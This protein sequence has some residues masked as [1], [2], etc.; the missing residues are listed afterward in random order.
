MKISLSADVGEGFGP[1]RLGNDDA[2]MPYISSANIACGMHAGDPT[3]MARTIALAKQHGVSIGAHPGFRDIQG[4]GRRHIAMPPQE[5][6]W[7]VTY[8]IGALQSLAAGQGVNVEFVKPHG[9]L[10]NIAHEDPDVA[11][12]IARGIRAADD[13]LIFVANCLSEMTRAGE[14]H[15]LQVIHEA[16]AD[17]RYAPNGR[18]LPRSDP[19]AVVRDPVQA[20]AQVLSML[21]TQSLPTTDGNNLQTPIDTICFHA[22]EPTAVDIVKHVRKKILDSGVHISEIVRNRQLSVVR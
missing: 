18:L 20:A 8:Q 19:L 4:F 14:N 15:G 6:E 5:I 17:R 12:A 21:E 11:N 10:N 2:L 7:L 22:D 16:Y 13:T 1:Y 9:A 3:T